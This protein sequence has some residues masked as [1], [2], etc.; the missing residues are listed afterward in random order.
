MKLEDIPKFPAIPKGQPKRRIYVRQCEQKVVRLMKAKRYDPVDVMTLPRS[1]NTEHVAYLYALM[2]GMEEGTIFGCA[3]DRAWVKL[4]LQ[5]FGKLSPGKEG[6]PEEAP[7]DNRGI[8][9][10]FDWQQSRHTLRDNSTVSGVNESLEELKKRG[11][12]TRA[13]V[14]RSKAAA[15]QRLR[16]GGVQIGEKK[17]RGKK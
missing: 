11:E 6:L 9:A 1:S 3:E 2:Q 8:E 17:Q 10:L 4:E 15:E 16:D 14:A 5:A 12:K 13:K 7:V